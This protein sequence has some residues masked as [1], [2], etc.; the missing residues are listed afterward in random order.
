MTQKQQSALARL[1]HFN[2]KRLEAV[3][4]RRALREA[5]KEQGAN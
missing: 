4:A 3:L 2:K 5:V 1:K